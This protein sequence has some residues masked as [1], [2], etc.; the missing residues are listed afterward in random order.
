M[1]GKIIFKV[2]YKNIKRFNG[3]DN[4]DGIDTGSSPW[5]LSCW[6]KICHEYPLSRY[7]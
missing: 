3:D 5:H 7:L 2:W 6:K 1:V 4:G